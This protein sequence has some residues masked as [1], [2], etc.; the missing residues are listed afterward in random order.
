M[1]WLDFDIGCFEAPVS[2]D[3]DDVCHD[4]KLEQRQA[5]VYSNIAFLMPIASLVCVKLWNRTDSRRTGHT[6]DLN[7]TDDDTT[8]YES[9]S[10]QKTKKGGT[11]LS[12]IHRIISVLYRALTSLTPSETL[13]VVAHINITIVSSLYHA[14]DEAN[15]TLLCSRPDFC[16]HGNTADV[17]RFADMLASGFTL[18]ASLMLGVDALEL[19]WLQMY[20]QA[21]LVWYWIY[22]LLLT[23]SDQNGFLFGMLALGLADVVVR[24]FVYISTSQNNEAAHYCHVQVWHAIKAIGAANI[25]ILLFGGA[26]AMIAVLMQYTAVF[27]S[28]SGVVVP[29]AAAHVVWHILLGVSD[30]L[31][32]FVC[33][34][35]P[36]ILTPTSHKEVDLI[37]YQRIVITKPSKV[38]RLTVTNKDNILRL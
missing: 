1:G 36:H 38:T 34:L 26:L 28:P 21:V 30:S 32:P 7:E 9:S 14:C 29:H 15:G 13:Y 19:R 27:V 8:H 20:H 10:I 5:L 6:Q 23:T 16:L 12:C 37:E 2:C 24:L 25:C 33:V 4:A 18:H 11:C 22:A 35:K 17:F 31:I 3:V